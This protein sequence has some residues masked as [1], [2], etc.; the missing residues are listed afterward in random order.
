METP[1]D[2]V[3]L[4]N[5]LRVT[6]GAVRGEV[7]IVDFVALEALRVFEPAVYDRIRARADMFGVLSG[8]AR[9]F[10]K[11]R[12][13]EQRTFHAQWVGE[14]NDAEKRK[15]VQHIVARLF[16]ETAKLLDAHLGI[17]RRRIDA[18]RARAISEPE[19]FPLYL[20]F[21]LGDQV[22]SRELIAAFVAAAS[23]P[24]VF[25]ERLLALAEETTTSG[26]TRASVMLDELSAQAEHG[27]APE[28]VAGVIKSLTN[29]GDMLW[30]ESDN[31]FMGVDTSHESTG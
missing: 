17:S 8:L 24:D 31:E 13:D 23:D 20:R 6:Y 10:P 9:V 2:I 21:A 22:L 4:T 16:P 27:F 28:H 3:R 18:R 15:A 25:A 5:S 14:I 11:A 19:Y 7:N 29:I 12:E 1:R 30:I 26:R